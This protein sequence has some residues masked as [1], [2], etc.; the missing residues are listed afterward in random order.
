MTTQTNVIMIL[1][2]KAISEKIS[3]YL[4][5]N[6]ATAFILAFEALL[7]V[8]A[9]ELIVGNVGVANAVGVYAFVALVVGVALYAISV[10]NGSKEDK[11]SP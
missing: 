10:I 3:Q 6:P 2:L 1:N 5:K 7:L 4:K 8:A 9:V 11:A